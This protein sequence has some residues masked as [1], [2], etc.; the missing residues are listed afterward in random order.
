MLI[1]WSF[2]CSPSVCGGLILLYDPFILV[3]FCII[4]RSKTNTKR[5][6][7]H[8][9]SLHAARCWMTKWCWWVSSFCW[10]PHL[11]RVAHGAIREQPLVVFLLSSHDYEKGTPL[12][13][14]VYSLSGSN[15]QALWLP[16]S[17]EGFYFRLTLNIK[18]RSVVEDEVMLLD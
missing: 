10:E 9:P 6:E 15:T 2:G 7:K 3:E 14:G 12:D 18:K 8:E 17:R 4:H 11:G 1:R 13:K 16:W 5:R